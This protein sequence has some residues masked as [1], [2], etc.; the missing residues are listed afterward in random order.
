MLHL[1]THM[2]EIGTHIKQDPID[3]CNKVKLS[4]LLNRRINRN[5]ILTKFLTDTGGKVILLTI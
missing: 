5:K 2:N 4:A 3:N 1:S